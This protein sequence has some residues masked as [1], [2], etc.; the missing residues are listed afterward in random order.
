M[1]QLEFEFEEFLREIRAM[2]NVANNF[3][4]PSAGNVLDAFARNL[5][6]IRSFPVRTPGKWEISRQFPLKTKVS[7]GEYEQGGRR[8]KHK[9][10]GEVSCVWTITPSDPNATNRKLAKTF[11]VTGK[12]SIQIRLVELDENFKS[13]ELAMW[14]MELGDEISPGCYFHIQVLGEDGRLDPP[15][16]HSL[17]IPRLPSLIFTPMAALEFVIAELFQDEWKQHAARE[18]D[19]MSEWRAIQQKRFHCLLT[20]KQKVVTECSGSP[21]TAIKLEKP[22]ADLFRRK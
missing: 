5:E 1:P 20:W 13:Q 21:W 3:L 6:T 15:F 7:D 2:K 17:S 18:T 9:V 22:P 12:A 10:F 19:P 4:D 14:R 8:G 16:P 11:V